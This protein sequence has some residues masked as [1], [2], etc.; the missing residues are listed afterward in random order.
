MSMNSELN[1]PLIAEND[2]LESEAPEL[3]PLALLEV[4]VQTDRAEG[5][6]R[7][8]SAKVWLPYSIEQIWQILTDYDRL[9][10]FIP[11]LA[12]SRQIEHPHG[13]IRIEQVGTQSLLKI[14]FC[15]RVVL[16]MVEQFPHQIDFFMVE[17]DFKQFSGSWVLQP[18]AEGQGT[19]LCYTIAVL[20]PR[21]MPISLIENRLKTSLAINLSAIR[22]RADV[23][24]SCPG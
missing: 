18:S 7:Q 24:F 4:E 10:E 16:D 19:V 17:G 14:K 15:A 1:A 13:G 12:K 5:R 8:L 6:Q 9:A 2:S 21:T 23:L 11:N 22:Q 20:P 3:L